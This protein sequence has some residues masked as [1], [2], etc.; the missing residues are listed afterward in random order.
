MFRR[1]RIY[2]KIKAR[3]YTEALALLPSDDTITETELSFRAHC[4]FRLL[5]YDKAKQ[6]WERLKETKLA[7]T[8]FNNQGYM[9]LEQGLWDKAIVELTRAR[10]LQPTFA[11]PLNNL[12]Y[13]YLMTDRI[14][15]G[16][17][18]IEKSLKLNKYNYYAV[19]N[20]GIYYMLKKQYGDALVVLNKAKAKDKAIDDMDV[21]IA[22]C[23]SKNGDNDLFS[24]MVQKFSD[25]ERIRLESLIQLF[26]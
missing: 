2:R 21:Y 4:F 15:E 7:Y 12:G 16:V 8:A 9:Y 20:I 23:Q 3:K 26:P 19:R 11:F 6:D 1:I 25:H 5:Q 22:I 18:M 13:A 17:E 10:E 24:N 14:E